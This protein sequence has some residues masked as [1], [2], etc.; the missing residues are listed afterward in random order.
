M[1][2]RERDGTAWAKG[3]R[4]IKKD[5]EERVIEWELVKLATLVLTDNTA[6]FTNNT[7]VYL[8]YVGQ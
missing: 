5:D 3:K 1:V 7:G 2:E 6:Y 4:C 8:R